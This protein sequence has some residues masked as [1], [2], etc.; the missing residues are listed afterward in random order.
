MSF[1]LRRLSDILAVIR[2]ECRSWVNISES[3]QPVHPLVNKK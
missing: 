2:G 3:G 1:A